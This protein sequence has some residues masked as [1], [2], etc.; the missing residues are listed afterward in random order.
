LQT[1]FAEQK[2]SADQKKS[3]ADKVGA[4][5][6]DSYFKQSK[7]ELRNMEMLF[8]QCMNDARGGAP[9]Q[10]TAAS[11]APAQTNQQASGAGTPQ[12][13]QNKP[14]TQPAQNKP[15]QSDVDKAAA[16]AKKAKDTADKLKGIFPGH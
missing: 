12:P 5:V 2:L 1:L 10:S 7:P 16:K 14:A 13:Q 8:Q 4:C 9:G 15:S 3:L 6:P 11:N